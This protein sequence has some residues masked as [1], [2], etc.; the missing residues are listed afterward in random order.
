MPGPTA[1]W[2]KCQALTLGGPGPHPLQ[3]GVEGVR[4]LQEAPLLVLVPVLDL[5]KLRLQLPL[6]WEEGVGG[7]VRLRSTKI[8][9]RQD[10]DTNNNNLLTNPGL[11]A[12]R[13]F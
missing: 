8:H 2:T 6:W 10:Y 9:S 5:Q 1:R 11:T 7:G 3:L 13:L 4:G 12:Y